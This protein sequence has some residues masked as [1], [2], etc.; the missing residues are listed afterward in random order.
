MNEQIS[1]KNFA[2]DYNNYLSQ[3]LSI[4]KLP[5]N[6]SGNDS[7]EGNTHDGSIA[8]KFGRK[9]PLIF[10]PS[11]M[12]L[13]EKLSQFLENPQSDIFIMKGY[14]GTG[15]STVLCLINDYMSTVAKK[16]QYGLLAPTGRAAMVLN[17]ITGSNRCT[18]VHRGIY[19]TPSIRKGTGSAK[20]FDHNFSESAIEIS[21][22]H[23][24]KL[25]ELSSFYSKLDEKKKYI[26]PINGSYQNDCN[27]LLLI[28]DE[29]SMIGNQYSE[30][31]EFRFGTGMLLNDI[32]QFA[33]IGEQS[34]HMHKIIFCG[35][36]A[37]LF[38]VGMN[39]S[40]ALNFDYLSSKL[41][42]NTDEFELS[43]VLRQ[44][45]NSTILANATKIRNS[46][47]TND[48]STLKIETGNDVLELSDTVHSGKTNTVPADITENGY[49]RSEINDEIIR[50]FF[51]ACRNM[52]NSKGEF[53]TFSNSEAFE[54]NKRIRRHIYSVAPELIE[55]RDK[56]IVTQNSYIYEEIFLANG[57]FVQVTEILP[58]FHK[59][60]VS[61][62]IKQKDLS[63]DYT[64]SPFVKY[65][66]N[67]GDSSTFI[68]TLEAQKVR[69]R[70]KEY[71]GEVITFDCWILLND[72]TASGADISIPEIRALEKIK[73][74]AGREDRNENEDQN[75]CFKEAIRVRYGYAITCHKSQG[76]EW[77][78]VFLY[79]LNRRARTGNE[80]L[81]HWYY[82]AVTRARK[83]L[84]VID[85]ADIGK[86]NNIKFD[87]SALN[88]C[89]VTI[90]HN[91]SVINNTGNQQFINPQHQTN[92][93][94]L[95]DA[96]PE[97]MPFTP[98][99]DNLHNSF[100]AMNGKEQEDFEPFQQIS[101][102]NTD[103]VSA[104]PDP[105]VSDES[106]QTQENP[107]WNKILL[108]YGIAKFDSINGWMARNVIT[109]LNKSGLY[110][111][112]IKHHSYLEKYHVSSPS[113]PQYKAVISIYYN[114]KSE[115]SNFTIDPKM[116]PL[117]QN[118][119]NELLC[120]RGQRYVE[121]KI[122]EGSVTLTPNEQ[123]I[124]DYFKKIVKSINA[125]VKLLNRQQYALKIVILRKLHDSIGNQNVDEYCEATV[126]YNSKGQV[127]NFRP[128]HSNSEIL[129]RDIGK[130][131]EKPLQ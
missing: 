63:S 17:K 100:Y 11:Q 15:K 92:E 32:F 40:P 108:Q 69:L 96:P 71:N 104:D 95:Y 54:I 42:F 27:P 85:P 70:K 112:D 87:A 105:A 131:L 84:F 16:W 49:Y 103:I 83:M 74:I 110:L 80:E 8:A 59:L 37:Q 106:L 45:S 120:L 89:T 76:N 62:N 12:T 81:F 113:D 46:I 121:E 93:D 31:N 25:A 124:L 5:E 1:L 101:T 26:I 44:N 65:S 48:F 38:P 130:L 78:Y 125:E 79:S 19:D 116:S 129:N 99:G 75:I 97:I 43:D 50:I 122:S 36:P 119:F 52:I 68:V 57:T 86:F 61:V 94:Y 111:T 21:V 55:V 90:P 114:G 2:S 18:T 64:G 20:T 123:E 24:E 9:N 58:N 91:P 4:S 39:F 7:S 73:A 117:P 109:I 127:S 14:A 67:N 35:D 10:T 77:D 6:T 53:I 98:Y 47:K 33:F 23:A 66:K 56:L 22:K 41:Q 3:K 82:T 118:V 128:N 72:L 30:M 28:F 102:C 115:I 60:E 126:Y 88:D 34:R 107:D 13:I 51:A 29:A